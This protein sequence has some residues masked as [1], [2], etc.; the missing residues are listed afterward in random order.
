MPA[1]LVDAHS[2]VAGRYDAAIA[3]LHSEGLIEFE[4]LD[5]ANQSRGH[6][7]AEFVGQGVVPK[8]NVGLTYIAQL[9]A[10]RSPLRLGGGVGKIGR[11]GQVRKV[12][13]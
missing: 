11:V 3:A 4:L 9:P 5:A 6:V 1:V 13:D 10:E 7:M 8:L 2:P 12:F